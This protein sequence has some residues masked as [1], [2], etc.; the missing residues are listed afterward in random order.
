MS[1]F[2]TRESDTSQC[3]RENE[4]R[5]DMW[6]VNRGLWVVDCGDVAATHLGIE[7]PFVEGENGTVRK[8]EKEVLERFAEPESALAQAHKVET[9]KKKKDNQ[10]AALKQNQKC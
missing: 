2:V 8:E 7:H 9:I 4:R 1:E 3:T 10:R 5:D 6:V